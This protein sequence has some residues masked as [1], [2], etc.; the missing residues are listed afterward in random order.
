MKIQVEINEE[1][2]LELAQTASINELP[3]SIFCQAKKE[4]IDLAVNEIKNKLVEKKYYTDK[5]SLLVEVK[6]FVYKQIESQIKELIEEKFN[7]KKI[8]DIVERHADKTITDWM[9][10]KIYTQ[11]ERLKKDIFIGS[12]NEIENERIAVQEAHE[13]EIEAMQ[14]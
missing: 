2:I 9:E 11:L 7:E 5:E 12:Y 8:K 1:K 4:A 6:G 3:S 13:A 14:E 10:K